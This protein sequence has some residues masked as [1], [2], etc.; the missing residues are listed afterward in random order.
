VAIHSLP[1]RICRP[2]VLLAQRATQVPWCGDPMVMTVFKAS[3]HVAWRA[4][5]ARVTR[6]PML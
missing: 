1:K 6:P 5:Q 3:G 4:S 2:A